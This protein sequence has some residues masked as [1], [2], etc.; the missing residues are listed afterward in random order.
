[1][2]HLGTW[3]GGEHSGAGLMAGLNSIRGISQP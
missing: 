1:M 3:F 2:G